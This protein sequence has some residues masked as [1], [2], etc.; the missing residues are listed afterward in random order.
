[1][2]RL[3]RRCLEKN[4]KRRLR[5]IGEARVVIEDLLAGSAEE[6]PVS[7]SRFS[8]HLRFAHWLVTSALLITALAFAWLYFRQ[9][10]PAQRVVR[11]TVALPAKAQVDSFVLSPDGR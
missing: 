11:T 8:K 10:P 1:M 9:T 7:A 5:D 3:V 6:Q 2:R 4:P